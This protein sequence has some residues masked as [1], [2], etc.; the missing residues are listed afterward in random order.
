MRWLIILFFIVLPSAVIEAKADPL[1]LTA[2]LNKSDL[3]GQL[4]YLR[5]PGGRLSFDDVAGQAVQD[6]FLKSDGAL[7]FGITSDVIWLRLIVQRE[8]LAAVEWWLELAP[9]YIGEATLYPFPDDGEVVR[10]EGSVAG[11]MSPLSVRAFK[12]RHSTFKLYLHDT[13]P[14]IFFIKIRSNTQLNARAY[15]WQPAF[16]AENSALEH[17]NLGMY[18]GAFVII[19][20]ICGLRLWVNRDRTD[21]WWLIYLIAEGFVIFRMNGLA[22]HYFFPEFP[23]F[24][25]GVGTL[26]LSCMVLAGSNF[27]IHAFALSKNKH[28]YSWQAARGIGALAIIFG[29]TRLIGLEPASTK[30]LF[31]LSFFLCL[32]NCAFSYRFLRSGEPSA[33]FYFV[34][35]WF[36]TAC[37]ILVLARNF[38]IMPAYQFIDYV[39]QS[40]MIIHA[41]L[42]SFGMILDRRET[43]KERRRASDYQASSESSQHYINLQK[44]MVT[45]VSHE[46]RNSLAMLNVS[47]HVISKRSDLPYDV[48]ERHRNIVRV[49]HQMRRVIDNF[50]LEERIQNADVKVLYEYT[51]MKS[52]LRDTVNLAA[53]YGKDQ[54]ISVEADDLP[55]H[56]WLDGGILRLVLT[57][58]LD[59]AIKYSG[60][61]SKIKLTGQYGEGILRMKVSDNGIGMTEASLAHLFEPYFKVNLKTEGVGIG[62]YMVRLMLHAHGGNLCVESKINGGTSLEFQMRVRPGAEDLVKNIYEKQVGH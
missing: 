11:I 14:K 5:D 54:T 16:Y 41:A 29:L 6:D 40:N 22:S 46:F 34:A 9:A 56:L 57:N 30:C 42:I 48:T 31:I 13:A 4:S 53:M 7:N 49:H 26:A 18:Y 17:L 24:S 50:L 37:V 45:L 8:P 10:T 23:S 1:V 20:S 47:M 62:L 3:S 43:A 39:W 60:S 52:L 38:G 59:N 25:A 51:E 61:G 28:P 35:I 36:M 27:G 44:R 55:E 32:L 33:K 19:V 58:L 21:F 2:H 12:V 15:L